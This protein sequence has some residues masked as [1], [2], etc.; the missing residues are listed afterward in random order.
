MRSR[1]RCWC[2]YAGGDV[3]QQQRQQAQGKHAAAVHGGGGGGG[4]G[5]LAGSVLEKEVAYSVS[6]VLQQ[7]LDTMLGLAHAAAPLWRHRPPSPAARTELDAHLL[8]LALFTHT[9]NDGTMGI[10]ERIKEIEYEMSRTQVNKA[11]S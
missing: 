5:G 2:G 10:L 7:H 9:Y 4:G 1:C 3:L 8:P 11:V 6:K